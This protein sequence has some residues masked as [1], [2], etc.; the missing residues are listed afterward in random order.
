LVTLASLADFPDADVARAAHQPEVTAAME[1]A[2]APYRKSGPFRNLTPRLDERGWKCEP[3]GRRVRCHFDG[4]VTCAAE[5]RI[6][7]PHE[8]CP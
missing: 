2:C 4:K 8:V 6:D 7:V 3:I 1:T 5:K